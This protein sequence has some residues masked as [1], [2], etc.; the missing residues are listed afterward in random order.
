[1]GMI[2][3]KK[4]IIFSTDALI[5][6]IIIFLTVLVVY[7]MMKYSKHQVNIESDV[8]KVY[9]TLKIGEIDNF[10]VKTLISQKEIKDLNKSILEQIGEFYVTNETLARSLAQ[11][12]LSNLN[13]SENIGIW[14][15]N[16]LLASKNST[17]FETAKNIRVQSQSISGIKEGE[18]VT[19]FSARA[20][21]TNNFQNK[22]FYF[23]GYV[24]D[25]NISLKVN[26]NDEIKEAYLEI[27]I[28]NEFD[29]YINNIYSGHYDKSFSEFTPAKYPLS[30]YLANFH[31]G[32][33]II[34]FKGNKLSITGGYLKIVYSSSA[35]YEE[36]KKIYF[37]GIKG[38]INLYD[39]VYI[40]SSIQN[41]NIFL[42]LNSNYMPFLIIG[43]K[44]VFNR[45]T[46]GE[47][48][49]TIP[50]SQL[51]SILNYSSLS[52]KTVPIRLGLENVSYLSQYKVKS[53]VI[54]V[55]DLSGSMA[56]YC[57]GTTWLCCFFRDGCRTKTN[58]NYC[59]GTWHEK[60]TTVKNASKSF[61][62]GILNY[63]GNMIGLTPYAN[64]FLPNYY[65]NLSNNTNSLKAKVDSWWAYGTTCIC[66]G[67]NKATSELV[68]NSSSQSKAIVVMSDG[69][70]NV[71]CSQQG[72]GNS[73]QDAIKA[74]CDAKSNYNITVHAV[75]FG[76]DTD[77][78]TLRAIAT[79][80]NGSYYYG[81]VSNIIGLYQQ[82]AQDII[83]ASYHEQTIESIGNILTTLYPDS[84]IEL[85]YTKG[86]I[87]YGLTTTFEKQFTDSYSGNF[88]VPENAQVLEAKVVSYSGPRW[89]DSVKIN[90]TSVYKIT[91][92]GTDYT[93]LGD[94]YSIFIKPEY[95]K[96]ENSVTITTGVSPINSTY[97]SLSNKIIYTIVKNASG[98]SS[99]SA[100]ASGCLWNIEFED[101][102]NISSSIPAN[103]LGSDKCYYSHDR[104]EYDTNN[105]LHVAVYN[106]LQMLDLNSNHKIDTKFAEQNLEISTSE[107]TGIPYTWSTEV[108]IR[109]WY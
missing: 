91:D 104:Q 10:Y 16:T 93:K 80:G 92:Y 18:S 25:G 38:I 107:I 50:N 70:A 75:G 9:S 30:S 22:Y 53:D 56:D 69:E 98:Y 23:G 105:A 31:N 78:T 99:I 42:H 15:E 45:T 54:S 90:N 3:E 71:R 26:Y 72:T 29:I 11:S 6:L 89:T 79:C 21:L 64:A 44:V 19:G 34:E 7:P 39:G 17:P 52:G 97:G 43:N 14:Y 55:I 59:S 63:S 28:N 37:P 12:V 101:G 24:G 88:S 76:S 20:Y 35:Q 85:N 66:C 86:L 8:I 68:A 109:E 74:A 27:A 57:T 102:S 96:K 94:P 84:Y 62:D 48:Q 33:N 87:P 108:Q 40:P 67:I 41:M 65:Y 77:T 5:A 13:T 103:Y 51:S 61:I 58:C 81:D 73:K 47:E 49:I 2:K 82:I 32:S 83:Q 46:S 36:Q 1:M 4:G 95:V 106:L 100:L 60:L